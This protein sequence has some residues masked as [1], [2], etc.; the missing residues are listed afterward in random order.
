MVGVLLC[1]GSPIR[2]EFLVYLREIQKAICRDSM[3]FVAFLVPSV[4]IFISGLKCASFRVAY[5]VQYVRKE[6]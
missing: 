3:S 4:T 5:I 2:K 1:C 6:S